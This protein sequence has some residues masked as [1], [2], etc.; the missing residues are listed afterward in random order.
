[1]ENSEN[2]DLTMAGVTDQST[3]FELQKARNPS[4]YWGFVANHANLDTN[5]PHLASQGAFS[6]R[7]GCKL[8]RGGVHLATGRGALWR[9]W[10]AFPEGGVHLDTHLQPNSVFHGIIYK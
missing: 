4:K 6:V 5:A 9:R 3:F 8:L 2:R 10:G 7:V 1:M